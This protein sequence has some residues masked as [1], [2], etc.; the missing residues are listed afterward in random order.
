MTKDQTIL[1]I[2]DEPQIRR[3]L[4]ITLEAEN[5]RV[6]D[7]GTGREGILL[8]ANHNPA[9]IILDLGLPD[10]DGT[11]VL[12]ELRMW[13]ST[14]VIILSVRNTED[15]IIRALDEGADDYITKPFS[16]A[17]LTARIKANLRRTQSI[18][19]EHII[20][21]GS[22]TIDLVKHLV[23]RDDYEIKLT[24][25]EFNLLS[26]FMNNIGKV[27]TYNIIFKSLWGTANSESA[28]SLRV[29]IGTLRK[30]IEE[31]PSRPRLIITE[32]GVGYRMKFIEK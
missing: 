21:N 11:N 22:I 15:E 16:P 4:H 7:A 32:S 13:S 10:G 9:L 1:I 20:S 29:F 6:I 3:I 24:H 19:G 2:D 25:M 18:E 17:E 27:L 28:Q 31:S 14:P 23:S 30:K 8:A 5:F 12:R 26:L